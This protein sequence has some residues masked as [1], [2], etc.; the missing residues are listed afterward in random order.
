MPKLVLASASP[1]RSELLKQLELEFTVFPS[2]AEETLLEGNL[3]AS[4]VERLAYEKARDVWQRIERAEDFVIL[5]ADTV[6]VLE[7]R[8]LGKPENAEEAREMLLA[9]S[10]KWH[11]VL[12]GIALVDFEGNL[13]YQGHEE[14]KVLFA[15]LTAE[16]IA[17]YLDSGEALDKAGAYGIQGRAAKFVKKINGCYFNVMGLPLAHLYGILKRKRVDVF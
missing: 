16:E 10:G 13:I 1:R 14:T 5:G 12:T 2:G 3:P 11:R 6:V 4:E 8:I 17:K 7:E 9:L 15:D